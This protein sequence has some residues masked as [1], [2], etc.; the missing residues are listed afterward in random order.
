MD[1]KLEEQTEKV[2]QTSREERAE[3]ADPEKNQ[4]AVGVSE[5]ADEAMKAFAEGGPIE[6]T[7]EDN[8]RLLRIIDWKLMPMMCVVYGLNYL[9]KTTLSYASVMGLKQDINLVKDNYQW[10]GSM[11][12]FG[13]LAWEYPTSILLQRLP[14]AKYSAF[15]IV[16]WGLILTLFAV[17]HNFPG[18]VAV[19][20]LLGVFEAAV[21]PGFALITSQATRINIWFS[22]NGWAQI[23]GG[24]VAYGIAVGS[25][26]LGTAIAPW[27]TIFLLTG[28]LTVALGVWFYW[29]IPDNQLNARW[30]KKEDRILAVERVRVN[31]QGIGNKHFKFY[32]FK[33]ALLDPMTW[34]FVFYAI[35]ADIP[36][37]GI[38]N[39]FSQLIVGFGY[40]P[41][42]SLLYGTP[43]GAVEVVALL[44]NGFLGDYYQQ[45]L[46][47]SSG[48]LIVAILGTA[49]MIALPETLPVGRLVGYYLTL[50]CPT[51][52][53][54]ILGLI[55]SNVA[56]YTKKTTVAALYLIGYCV[57]NIIGPQ[58][59]RPEQAPEYTAAKAT[60]LACF[61]ACLVDMYFIWWWYTRQ[62]AKK[63]KLRAEPGYTKVEN[64]EYVLP[65]PLET[66][67]YKN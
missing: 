44:L 67:G 61:S 65:L 40:T 58:T 18:A 3:I 50:A 31:Q 29:L 25:R 37:G 32:Q 11:F 62:N 9:D 36:N 52:F 20:F 41:E 15:C 35:T 46:L 42:Q 23:F 16:T 66:N 59:F 4:K 54:C 45:R 8:K 28:L 21:T 51:P 53:V 33:E 63:A 38:S 19:R 26:T 43:A 49:L 64:Q 13:Y 10:L 60:I 55:S 39:F 24:L 7:P 14:L 48:G 17:V 5:D 2:S 1:E 57:G 34:A 22:F 6:L 56:G 12:Y 27:K 47:V 30:L